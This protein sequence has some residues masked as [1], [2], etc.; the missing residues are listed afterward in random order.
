MR[1]LMTGLVIATVWLGTATSAFAAPEPGARYKG[2]GTLLET[3]DEGSG[4]S[5][6]KL[7]IAP[8]C[9][10]APSDLGDFGSSG[11][12][13]FTVK[14]DGSFTN[15]V[16]G[17]KLPPGSVLFRGE[18]SDDGSKVTGTVSQ[19]KFKD[20]KGLSCDAFKGKFSAKLID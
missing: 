14:A 17:R 2:K 13:P 9:K 11:I 10:K 20:S 16:S 19:S 5:V 18:F 12:G 15:K 8:E 1:R 3:N 6:L 7:P 4:V